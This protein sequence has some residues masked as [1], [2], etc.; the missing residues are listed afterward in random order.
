VQLL[1]SAERHF[2]YY[3]LS[4]GYNFLPGEA[5]LGRGRAL[6][7][8]FYLL[9]GIGSTDF[10]GDKKFTVN[11]GAGFRVLPSDWLAVH[12]TVQDRVFQSDVLGV[13]KLTNNIEMRIG[14]T[15]FF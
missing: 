4:L 3:D 14:T 9:G 8:A 10:G 2:T 5:F 11:F 15:V 6:T 1:T 12:I 7:S 13:D